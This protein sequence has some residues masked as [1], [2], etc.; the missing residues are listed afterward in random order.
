M[1]LCE[2]PKP[3]DVFLDS[4]EISKMEKIINEFF[5]NTKAYIESIHDSSIPHEFRIR[6]ASF[7]Y[8]GIKN[9]DGVT[10]LSYDDNYIVAGVVKTRNTYNNLRYTFFRSLDFI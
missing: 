7:D 10:Y 3:V 6:T 2:I 1:K 4:K 5:N 8:S 9:D